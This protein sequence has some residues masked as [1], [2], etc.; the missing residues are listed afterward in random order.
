MAEVATSYI[1]DMANE[2][3]DGACS[4]SVVSEAGDPLVARTGPASPSNF[5]AGLRGDPKIA[6]FPLM[7]ALSARAHR[8]ASSMD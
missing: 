1:T 7:S 3:R 8:T 4:R 2:A 6:T 5:L